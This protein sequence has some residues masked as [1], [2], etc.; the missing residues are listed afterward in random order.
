[1]LSRTVKCPYGEGDIGA[2]L[3][4]VQKAHP[5]TVIGSYP[6]FDGQTFSTD[7]V[8]R[9]RSEGVLDAA[10]AA[11]RAMLDE[12]AAVKNKGSAAS[13]QD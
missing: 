4:A 12:V 13:G 11:V 3:G 6:K 9:A 5:D 10:E 7:L 1:M 8:I 2:P